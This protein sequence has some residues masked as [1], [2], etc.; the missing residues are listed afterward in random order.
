MLFLQLPGDFESS[1]FINETFFQKHRKL[2]RQTGLTAK[3]VAPAE[4]NPNYVLRVPLLASEQPHSLQV[5]S[6]SQAQQLVNSSLLPRDNYS[7][8]ELHLQVRGPWTSLIIFSHTRK[9]PPFRG[10]KSISVNSRDFVSD[11]WK[12]NSIHIPLEVKPVTPR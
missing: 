6:L 5:K 7:L 4:I 8:P 1:Y 2:W 12:I 10:G 9:K 3:V 11:A